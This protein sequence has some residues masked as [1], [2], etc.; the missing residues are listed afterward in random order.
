MEGSGEGEYEE[1]RQARTNEELDLVA[2]CRRGERLREDLLVD[3]ARGSLP[4]SRRLVE[5]K[6]DLKLVRLARRKVCPFRQR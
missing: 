2:L 5:D 3:V 1:R 6:V 4:P